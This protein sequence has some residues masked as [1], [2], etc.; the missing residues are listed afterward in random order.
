MFSSLSTALS[1]LNATTTAINLVGNDLANLNTIGYKS[2]SAQFHDLV[3]QSL[4]VAGNSSE[5]GLG[6]ANTTAVRNFQQGALQHTGG[7][8]D[9]AVEGNGFFVVRDQN[10]QTLYTRNGSFQVD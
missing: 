3:A 2:N 10:N 5:S 7:A 8:T 4:G 1:G 9:A 6:V